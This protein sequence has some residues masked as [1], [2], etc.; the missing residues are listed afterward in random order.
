MVGHLVPHDADRPALDVNQR[1]IC[2]QKIDFVCV[3][4]DTRL[5]TAS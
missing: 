1:G 5:E 3:R 2:G 4:S